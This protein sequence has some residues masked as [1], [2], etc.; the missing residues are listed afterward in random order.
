[1]SQ[2]DL[3]MSQESKLFGCTLL[4]KHSSQYQVNTNF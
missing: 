4:A 2:Y 3:N 1:M